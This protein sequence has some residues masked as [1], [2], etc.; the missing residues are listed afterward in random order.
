MVL[1]FTGRGGINFNEVR[2]TTI[3]ECGYI[4]NI[5]AGQSHIHIFSNILH[6]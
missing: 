2:Y 1:C 6:I 5:P 3:N 4:Y